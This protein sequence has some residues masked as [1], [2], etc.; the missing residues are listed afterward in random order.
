V[1]ISAA[2]DGT[3]GASHGVLAAYDESATVVSA[4]PGS[5]LRVSPVDVARLEPMSTVAVPAAAALLLALAPPLDAIDD[6]DRHVPPALGVALWHA[7]LKVLRVVVRGAVRPHQLAAQDGRELVVCVLRRCRRR[8]ADRA[9]H[10]VARRLWSD[11]N[12]QR[13]KP[14]PNCRVQR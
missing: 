2:A 12:H 14:K 7:S 10:G 3:L 1:T 5:G 4:A 13:M 6:A 11:V 8:A 9:L